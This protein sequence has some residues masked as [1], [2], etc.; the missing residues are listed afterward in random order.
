MD[1]T[2]SFIYAYMYN[3]T[4][5]V[6][7]G[8]CDT[9]DDCRE[10]QA[11][12]NSQC[13]WGMTRLHDAYGMGLEM[14]AKTGLFTVVDSSKATWVESVWDKVVFRLFLVTS[15]GMQVLELMIGLILTVGS[16]GLT[17]W[18]RKA[19]AKSLKVA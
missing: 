15:K 17:L 13:L 12:V 7:E 1:L 10:G 8:K 9:V 4:A 6:R 16:I 19:A 3:L 14:D 18:G 2:T 11:C 5:T